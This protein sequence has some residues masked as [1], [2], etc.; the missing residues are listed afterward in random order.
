METPRVKQRRDIIR[1]YKANLAATR[2]QVVT[3]R[4][5]ANLDR[6]NEILSA[7]DME[8]LS[9]VVL[10]DDV[11][12]AEV[13]RHD[14]YLRIATNVLRNTRIAAGIGLEASRPLATLDLGA[15]AGYL[16]FAARQ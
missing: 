3:A 2:A 14:K 7:A 6:L 5:N 15:G 8:A 12:D 9:H 1:R 4:E 13:L 10:P 16:S 11:A